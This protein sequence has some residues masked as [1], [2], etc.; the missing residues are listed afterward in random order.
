MTTERNQPSPSQHLLFVVEDA[1]TIEGRGTILTPG[2]LREGAPVN[3]LAGARLRLHRPDGSDLI[4]DSAGEALSLNLR[5]PYHPVLVRGL[6]KRDVP[7]GTQVWYF[8][9]PEHA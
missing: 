3:T 7:R 1:F 6:D 5:Y 9:T 4:V 2:F 8:P